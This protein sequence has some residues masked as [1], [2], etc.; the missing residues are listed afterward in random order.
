MGTAVLEPL[1]NVDEI[2]YL[3]FASVYRNFSTLEDFE[4][5]I[6]WLR[7]NTNHNAPSEDR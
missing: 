3:R 4:D 2:A 1:R 6:Q 7:N 5:A